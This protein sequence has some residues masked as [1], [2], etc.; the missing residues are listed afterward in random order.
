MIPVLESGDRLERAEF[1]RRYEARTDDLRCELIGG[2]VYVA[3]PFRQPHARLVSLLAGW[4]DRY[5]EAT[6]GIDPLAKPSLRLGPFD[7]PQPDL[8]LRVREG[9][10]S[11]I[12]ADRY[13]A[14]PPELVIEIAHSSVAHDLH[15]KKDCY[16]R[17]GVRE[18]L[19]VLVEEQEVRWFARDGARYVRL[20]PEADG[21][22]RSRVFPGL[23]LDPRALFA[24]ERA[25]LS[26]VL[27]EGLAARERAP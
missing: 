27:R 25:R 21:T 6:P 10:M 24:G 17:H 18:Y 1:E 3:S 11:H 19:V 23:W 20:T 26:A 14:G 12:D 5:A 22:L 8:L 4:L 2:V 16:E 7:E 9:G 15:D 13:V